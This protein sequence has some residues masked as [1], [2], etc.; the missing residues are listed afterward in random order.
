MRVPT[1]VLAGRHDP[2]CPP[3][4]SEEL[5]AGIPDSRLVVYGRSGHVPFVEE[6]AAFVAALR[7][8]LAAPARRP[9]AG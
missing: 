9:R 5:A 4:C 8:F 1:L 6:P 2:Q 7:P 3:V